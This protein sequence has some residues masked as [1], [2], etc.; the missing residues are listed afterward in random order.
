MTPPSQRVAG[1]PARNTSP[2]TLQVIPSSSESEKTPKKSRFDDPPPGVQQALCRPRRA[3]M[4]L[5][6][7]KLL[8][9]WNEATCQKV[10]AA[11][12][13]L[14]VPAACFTASPQA[15]ADDM[16]HYAAHR[17]ALGLQGEEPPAPAPP[18]A[19]SA[20]ILAGR[21]C[22]FAKHGILECPPGS[23]GH[24]RPMLLFV[25]RC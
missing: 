24:I 22:A 15:A 21:H 10:A 23:F 18:P 5:I 17:K 9:A 4:P 14:E 1:N 16:E 6:G 11:R 20:S 3:V 2:Q 8:S 25:S 12:E 7:G 13:H 19:G